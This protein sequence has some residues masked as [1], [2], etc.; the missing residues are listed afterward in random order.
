MIT[1]AI[2]PR[3]PTAAELGAA[4]ERAQVRLEA[5]DRAGA[6]IELYE[7][8]GIEQLL[9]QAQITTYSGAVG[10]M[11]L[12]GNFRAK[13]ANPDDYKTTLDKFSH[14]IDQ[15]VVKLARDSADDGTPEAFDTLGIMEADRRVWKKE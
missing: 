10:G 11:A 6:Y 8:T 2:E 1:G 15:E 3:T 5:G 4:A 12:E 9:L 14:D 13:H 7:V